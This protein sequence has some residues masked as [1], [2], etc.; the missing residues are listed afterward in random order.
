[1]QCPPLDEPLRSQPVAPAPTATCRGLKGLS[2]RITTWALGRQ[3]GL[4]GPWSLAVA[5]KARLGHDTQSGL[6]ET[7]SPGV[8]MRSRPYPADSPTGPDDLP[9]SEDL[10]SA[11]GV[12]VLADALRAGEQRAIAR[13]SDL[14]GHHVE[15]VLIRTI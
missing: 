3:I 15:R 14:Y 1:M 12:N 5:T 2:S 7:G 11:T 6:W 8:D 4:Y 10:I 13:L 9:G